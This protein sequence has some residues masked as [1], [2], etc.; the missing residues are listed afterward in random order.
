MS[1][2][3]R[4]LPGGEVRTV[5]TDAVPLRKLFPGMTPRR[6]SRIEVIEEG[7][8]AGK[9]HVDFTLLAHLTGDRAH[10]VCLATP[11]ESYKEAND[12]E[13]AWL[14]ENYVGSQAAPREPATP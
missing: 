14:T 2:T 7:R 12:A 4:F 13:V 10:C 5:Y 6:A 11:F 1:T 9:F 3:I 8:H